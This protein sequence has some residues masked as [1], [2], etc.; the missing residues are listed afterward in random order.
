MSWVFV[1]T[2][3]CPCVTRL[4]FLVLVIAPA[5]RPDLPSGPC[6]KN[7]LFVTVWYIFEIVKGFVQDLPATTLLE[8]M[9]GY[10]LHT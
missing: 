2:V 9:E 7:V 6:A 4:G 1:S 10:S 5:H 8:L 3:N